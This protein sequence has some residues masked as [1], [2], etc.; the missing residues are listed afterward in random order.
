MLERDF[1]ENVTYREKFIQF[2][3][4]LH[5]FNLF[6]NNYKIIYDIYKFEKLNLPNNLINY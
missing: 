2:D 6:F 4:L 1:K 5:D 3:H